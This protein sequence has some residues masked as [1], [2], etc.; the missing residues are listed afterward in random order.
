MTGGWRPWLAVALLFLAQALSHLDRF[1][2]SLLIGPIKAGLG[3]SDFQVGLL[4][5]PAFAVFYCTMALPAG[6]LADRYSRRKLLAGAIAIWCMMTTMA[7]IAD[8]F[9]LLLLSRLGVGLGEA[10]LTPCA[11]SLIGDYF[12]RDR[13]PRA[14]ALMMA[15]TTFGSAMAFLCGGPLVAW[16]SG[17]PPV[18]LPIAGETAQ[19]QLVFLVAGPPG[20]LLAAAILAIREPPRTERIADLIGMDAEAHVPLRAAVRFM[21]VRWRAFGPLVIGNAASLSIG[22]LSLWNVALFER[23][24]GWE[25]R[26]FGITAGIIYLAIG[27]LGY[28]L[29]GW[30][31]TRWLKRGRRDATLRTF[32]IGICIVVPATILY[33]LAPSGELAALGFAFFMLGQ[34]LCGTAGPSS[35]TLLTSSDMRSTVTA[36][37]FMILSL[38]SLVIGPLPIGLMVDWFG[39]PTALRYAMAIEAAVIGVP[40]IL[41]VILGMRGFRHGIVEVEQMIAA[42]QARKVEA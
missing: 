3:L 14:V 29:A 20:L 10:A 42:A 7:G 17:L 12:D 32:L 40:A 24:W 38:T 23:T 6:Y 1:L 15:G 16:I 2:P 31:A 5:G 9:D 22:T 26:Q 8:R 30:I 33:P 4:L 19:W 11:L 28:P 13:R 27:A 25:V 37:Y 18:I 35:V 39:D 36:V 21:L 34:C 41:I